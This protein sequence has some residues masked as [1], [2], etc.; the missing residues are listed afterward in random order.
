MRAGSADHTWG[1]PWYKKGWVAP[2]ATRN[3]AGEIS[4]ER[5]WRSVF[6][7]FRIGI[8]HVKLGLHQIRVF[9]GCPCR[10]WPTNEMKIGNGEK[11]LGDPILNVEPDINQI[12]IDSS[13][14][15]Y[16]AF[17]ASLSPWEDMWRKGKTVEQY[18]SMFSWRVQSRCDKI[19]KGKMD[20][21]ENC[22]KTSELVT[23]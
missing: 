14:D 19:M 4:C 8:L 3:N 12:G 11:T 13:L 10:D 15:W 22:N 21:W 18:F 20:R 7:L 2:W 17:G 9:Q 23:N 6:F 5:K 16:L 1:R